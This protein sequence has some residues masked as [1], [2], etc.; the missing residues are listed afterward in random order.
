MPTAHLHPDII[1]DAQW[2]IEHDW[3]N[4]LIAK[5]LSRVYH[6]KLSAQCIKN[7]RTGKPCSEKCPQ[8]CK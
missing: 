6:V 7:I 1:M 8:R 4:G 3:T 2:H 5:V